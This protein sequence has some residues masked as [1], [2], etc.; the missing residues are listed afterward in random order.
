MQQISSF[1]LLLVISCTSPNQSSPNND[2]G[3]DHSDLI[4]HF[5]IKTPDYHIS[6]AWLNDADVVESNPVISIRII[7]VG[8]GNA[9]LIEIPDEFSILFDSGRKLG[10]SEHIYQ[11]LENKNPQDTV[12]ITSHY[13][14][15]HIGAMDRIICGADGLPG[16]GGID[17]DNDGITD[18]RID[19][20]EYGWSGSDDFMP[21]LIIDRG[22]EELPDTNDMLEYTTSASQVRTTAWAGQIIPV[23]LPGL[24]IEIV[25][26]D[27][28]L[29]DD[30]Y[31]LPNY[32]NDR[33]LALLIE[34]H[35]F[36]MLIP[37]DLPAFVEARLAQLLADRG[38][39]LDLLHIGHHGSY[40]STDPLTLNLLTPETAVISVGDS[41]SCGSGFNTYGHPSQE[42]LDNLAQADVLAI[43]QTQEGGASMETGTCNPAAEQIWPRNYQDMD[44][45]IANSDLLITSDGSSYTV[46]WTN[47]SHTYDLD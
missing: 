27:G 3:S 39:D 2:A 46:N 17:D 28:H 24:K 14:S 34:Y 6:D 18:G 11:L 40:T 30:D 33:S 26:S 25:A 47:G 19:G 41:P 42:T 8:Q 21:G 5:E 23:A 13:D 9:T 31:I 45:I 20:N 29:I 12:F 15:D 10:D 16:R 22:L 4:E 7:D 37:S 36:K 44:K 32:E 1:L 38:V 35:N 43:Y